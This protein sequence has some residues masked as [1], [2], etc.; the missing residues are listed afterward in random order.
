MKFP[1][2][3][4]LDL[5]RSRIFATERRE[6]IFHLSP[7][8]FPPRGEAEA[9]DRDP[10]AM[11]LPV[12]TKAPVLWLGGGEPLVHPAV[13]RIALALNGLRRNVFVHT[14]GRRLRPRIH[15]FHPDER[16]F[17][18]VEFAGREKVHDQRTDEPGSF[19]RIIEGIR[20][21]K[22]SG[23]HVCTHLTV[24]EQTELCDAGELFEYLDHYDVDGF[25]VSSG[26]RGGFF[27]PAMKEKLS[28]VRG[29]VRCPR[30]ERFSELLEASY[31]TLPLDKTVAVARAGARAFE[32]SA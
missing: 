20:A 31:K 6:A 22:L 15:E 23:F 24:D 14:D 2:R 30:W 9:A 3:L 10:A 32:E 27:S 28:E 13:G 4:S 16:L 17:L 19:R 18:T 11:A 29:L 26:G 21:A 1:L 8:A 5:I 25:I 12:L 7:E